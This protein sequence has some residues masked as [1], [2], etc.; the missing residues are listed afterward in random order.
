[1]YT[2]SKDVVAKIK[3]NITGNNNKD[4]KSGRDKG[5]LTYDEFMDKVRLQGNKCYVC[6]Q[7]FKY[8]GGKWC[9]FFPSADRIYN[10]TSHTK[11]NIGIACLFC[12]IR[13]FKGISEKKC[14]LCDGL[15][16]S[17]NGDII[18]KSALFYSLGNDN[19]IIRE[20]ISKFGKPKEVSELNSRRLEHYRNKL[21]QI[22]Y[23]LEHD[24]NYTTYI[25]AR[26]ALLQRISDIESGANN[27]ESQ[28]NDADAVSFPNDA[29]PFSEQA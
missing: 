26:T 4:V 27:E 19:N 16:H 10:Y 29:L 12:N 6:S 15:H 21:T 28:P 7:E 2:L 18:T 1:M 9:Y 11:D 23:I 8:N 24:P 22:E 5:T 14:G 3:K 25:L 20:Y 17:Y 13:M